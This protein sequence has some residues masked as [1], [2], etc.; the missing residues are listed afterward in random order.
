MKDRKQVLLIGGTGFIG[1]HISKSLLEKGHVVTVISR[2][3]NNKGIMHPNLN[4]HIADIDAITFQELI[5]LLAGIDVVIFAAGADDRTLAKRYAY[6]FFYKK[7]VVPVKKLGEAMKVNGITKFIILGSYFSWLN[8][9]KPE[10]KLEKQHPYIRSRAEQIR[11]GL[12]FA[13]EKLRVIILELPYVFGVYPYKKP[14]W[15]GL[16]NYT[17]TVLPFLFYTTGGTAAVSVMQVTESVSICIQNSITSGSYP[18][19]DANL[20]WDEMIC[21]FRSGKKIRIIHLKKWLLLPFAK[22]LESSLRITNRESGLK[23]SSFLTIQ[24]N[25]TFVFP[26]NCL[27]GFIPNPNLL[28]TAIKEMTEISK[29]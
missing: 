8:R 19:A 6:D 4:Y 14:M 5:L 3:R 13:D 20:T 17:N 24:C 26:E 27:Q 10:M 28:D 9:N 11:Q 18:V 15:T 25:N 23:P 21:K 29:Q 12:S 22:L 2:N 1:Y 16:I 7:N